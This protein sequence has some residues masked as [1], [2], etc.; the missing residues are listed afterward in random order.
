[1]IQLSG[2]QMIPGRI[3]SSLPTSM[4]YNDSI[5]EN[6]FQTLLLPPAF[7]YCT[8]CIHHPVF[9]RIQ[10]LQIHQEKLPSALQEHTE[11]GKTFQKWYYLGYS[12]IYLPREHAMYFLTDAKTDRHW[13]VLL[14]QKELRKSGYLFVSD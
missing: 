7:S 8:P 12:E 6:G 4:V 10:G 3:V 2:I 13:P 14:A 1:M 9:M 11:T 5:S